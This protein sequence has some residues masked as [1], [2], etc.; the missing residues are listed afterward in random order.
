MNI[1]QPDESQIKQVL[2]HYKKFYISFGIILVCIGLLFWVIIPQ[3]QQYTN[4]NT[5]VQ[6]VKERIAILQKNV[7]FI[8]SVNDEQQTSQ[9]QTTTQALPED[10]DYAGILYAVR[11]A[12]SKSGVGIGDFTFNI[13][14]L[15]AKNV[16]TKTT[17]FVL[18]NLNVLG[19]PSSVSRFLTEL[20]KSFPLSNVTE[21]HLNNR[22]SNIIV[23]FY[24]KPIPSLRV[25]YTQPVMPTS[26][27][28]QALLDTLT[29]WHAEKST[30]DLVA[31]IESSGSASPFGQ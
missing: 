23:L 17:P 2:L 26:P 4:Q 21:I 27:S 8:A 22:F 15:S 12:S 5:Q 7:S 25:N 1:I 6:D 31:P 13:G 11:T 18:M 3:I 30:F 28:N 14:E 20:A 24:Y 19:D 10:K 29:G 9:L 16:I